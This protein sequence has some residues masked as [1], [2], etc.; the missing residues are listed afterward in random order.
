MSAESPERLEERLGGLGS[1]LCDKA[2]THF[3][4]VITDEGDVLA[5]PKYF[6]VM[7]DVN[8]YLLRVKRD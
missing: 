8:A 5:C 6:I 2:P 7:G 3:P 4:A 1:A